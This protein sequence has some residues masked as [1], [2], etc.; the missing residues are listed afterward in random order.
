MFMGKDYAGRMTVQ[1]T[2]RYRC[3]ADVTKAGLEV[4]EKLNLTRKCLKKTTQLMYVG[5]GSKFK[6]TGVLEIELV[7]GKEKVKKIYIC[8]NLRKGN[9]HLPK[10]ACKALMQKVF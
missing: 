2:S 10:G 6:G 3:S 7:L 9:V 4:L 5:S 1:C 8:H